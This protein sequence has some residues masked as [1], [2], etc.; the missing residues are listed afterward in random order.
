[1]QKLAPSRS[2]GSPIGI[3]SICSAHPLVIKAAVRQAMQDGSVL[4]VEATCNQVNQFGGYT[5]MMPADF[6]DLVV[7]IAS[8]QGMAREKLILGGDHLGPNP[9]RHLPAEVAMGHAEEMVIA[10][11]RAGFT[12]IHLDTSMA[13]AGDEVPLPESTIAR[14]AAQLCAVAEANASARNICYIIGT[15]VPVPG[16]STESLHEIS[17]TSPEGVVQT[18]DVHRAAFSEAELD[19]VWPRVIAIVV[20]PGVE[21]NHD[22]VVDYS[23]EKAAEL[24]H[25]LNSE[26]N[27]VYEAHSTDYQRADSYRKL[28]RDGFAILKVGPALTFALREALFSLSFIEEELV[29]RENCSM[30][31]AIVE[32][33][34]LRQPASWESHYTGDVHAQFLLRRYSY[35]DR[36][37][38]YWGDPSVQQAVSTL[39]QNLDSVSIPE[40]ML[41]QYLPE[42]CNAVR[43]GQIPLVAEELILHKI[44]QV[45]GPYALGCRP[46]V[47]VC[48]PVS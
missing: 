27:L 13:C 6:A 16:G 45:L 38:Y 19:G 18:L 23:P 14:R 35:S 20:Q 33:A 3:Y 26:P 40:T 7:E 42:Q 28:V 5:G 12:K 29:G 25:L 8:K 36:I 47:E 43:S 48:S 21:F 30:L 44:Q 10:Y 17:V 39:I 24:R 15:E 1:L 37:R 22:S 41:S 11:A 46:P 34:M 31:P 4:L 2:S 32:E 9:W